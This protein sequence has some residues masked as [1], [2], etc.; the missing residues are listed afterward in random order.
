[1][2]NLR[3]PKTINRKL[4]GLKELGLDTNQKKAKIKEE[5]HIIGPMVIR[6]MSKAIYSTENVGHYGL[7]FNYYSH[8]TSPIRRY[9]DLLIHRILEARINNKEYNDNSALEKQCKHI[10]KTEKEAVE[11]ER[12]STKYMQVVFLKDKIGETFLGKINGLTDWGFYVELNDNKCE[13]L[14]QINSLPN[15]HYYFDNK[16]KKIIGHKT[17]EAFSIGQ[18]VEVTVKRTDLQKRQIDFTLFK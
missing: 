3:L 12:A 6:S 5:L 7:A 11:A 9:A 17:Q 13:G 1:M 18:Q 4:N 16:Q 10:S 14:V 8:F 2:N 15:D